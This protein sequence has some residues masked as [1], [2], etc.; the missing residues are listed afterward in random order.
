MNNMNAG[1]KYIII[2]EPG[3]IAKD[4][5]SDKSIFTSEQELYNMV[6]FFQERSSTSSVEE[7]NTN[8]VQCQTQ[9]RDTQDASTQ[10]IRTDQ[11]GNIPVLEVSPTFVR[12]NLTTADLS[13]QAT[14]LS[15]NESFRQ[16]FLYYSTNDTT[17][18]DSIPPSVQEEIIW[19]SSDEEE[20][21][22]DSVSDIL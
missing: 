4:I 15:M 17:D 10:T 12:N 14:V 13:H 16:E 6:E 5:N 20:T 1:T 21:A 3:T 9:N 11:L 22:N 7:I 19:L 2:A 8:S 18:T